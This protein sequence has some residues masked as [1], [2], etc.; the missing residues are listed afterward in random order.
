MQPMNDERAL[1]ARLQ[2]LSEE[3]EEQSQQ[4][5]WV[6]RDLGGDPARLLGPNPFAP[7]RPAAPRPLSL[8][9]LWV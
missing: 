7:P 3:W 9:G 1:R 5:Y 2:S 6:V 8:G 4:L